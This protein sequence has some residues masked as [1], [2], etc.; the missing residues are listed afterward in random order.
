MRT[1]IVALSLTALNLA[2]KIKKNPTVCLVNKVNVNMSYYNTSLPIVYGYLYGK[3]SRLSVLKNCIWASWLLW[4]LPARQ[5]FLITKIP[6]VT[7]Y[8]TWLYSNSSTIT[9]LYKYLRSSHNWNPLGL[10]LSS[11]FLWRM[12][13]DSRTCRSTEIPVPKTWGFGLH[14]MQGS[15]TSESLQMLS[16]ASSPA[17]DHSQNAQAAGKKLFLKNWKF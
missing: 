8:P 13:E 2:S 14:S 4:F 12:R 15:A 6:P 7:P 5:K 16:G 17:L 3:K 10:H 11:A 1:Q 9:L